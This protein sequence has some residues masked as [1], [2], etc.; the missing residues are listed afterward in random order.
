MSL[1]RRRR[2]VREIDRRRRA[3]VLARRVNRRRI[4]EA[5]VYSASARWIEMR[6]AVPS[7]RALQIVG[8]IG[9][10]QPFGQIER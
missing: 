5:G 2:V 8:G 9:A 6:D 10:D 1:S 4:A 7:R 3:V